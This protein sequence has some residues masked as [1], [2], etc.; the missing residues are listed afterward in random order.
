MREP[1]I[2][3]NYAET[4][5]ALARKANDLDGWGAMIQD[6][7]D[8]IERDARLR[9]FLQ[10]PRIPAERKNEIL[11]RAF[12]DRLPRLFVRFIQA[13]VSHHRQALLGAIAVEYAALVDELAN[14][15]HA[16]VIVAREPDPALRAAVAAGVSRALG[17][18]VVPH[19]SVRPEIL[20]GLI[21]R[22]GDTV[23]DG[24]VRR[25]LLAL[26]NR[27]VLGRAAAF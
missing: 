8:A 13:V 3:R 23:I 18:T 25:R 10:S 21:V 1:T 11:G 4:L 20:G 16:Q 14:R 5:V 17:K 6:V 2:A 9:Q 19:F 22:V 15:V 27:L 7:A 26:R 24:S 12:Q